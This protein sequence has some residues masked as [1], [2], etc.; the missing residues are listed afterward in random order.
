[1]TITV[2]VLSPNINNENNIIIYAIYIFFHNV[3]IQLEQI[4]YFVSAE[5]LVFRQF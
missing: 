4:Y 2:S 5:A 1:M 3:F